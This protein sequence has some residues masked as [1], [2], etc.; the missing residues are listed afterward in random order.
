MSETPQPET[1][2]DTHPTLRVVKDA[3][4]NY[5]FSASDVVR[6]FTQ[7]AAHAQ[8]LTHFLETLA[9]SDWKADE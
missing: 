8:E 9:A 5:W 7:G 3:D 4:G 6:L 2:P 1:E